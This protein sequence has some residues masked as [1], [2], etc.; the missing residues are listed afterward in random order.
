MAA[1]SG[2]ESAVGLGSCQ[3]PWFY[4]KHLGLPGLFV[5]EHL[6][7]PHKPYKLSLQTV[8]CFIFPCGLAEWKG[9]QI[10]WLNHC[11]NRPWTGSVVVIAVL[12]PCQKWGHFPHKN[13]ISSSNRFKS[14]YLIQYSE[15]VFSVFLTC[16]EK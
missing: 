1:R 7:S 9:I 10:G 11:C 3:G 5:C 16:D 12:P 15:R 2:L 4:R 14:I 6:P 8:G 13:E